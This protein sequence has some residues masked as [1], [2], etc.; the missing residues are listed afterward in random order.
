VVS[1]APDAELSG[2]RD[3]IFLDTPSDFHI[4]ALEGRQVFVNRDICGYKMFE[5]L[6]S[7]RENL[8]EIF[9]AVRREFHRLSGETLEDLAFNCNG[10][11]FDKREFIFALNVFEELGLIAFGDGKLTVYRGIKAELTDSALYR[12][13][14]DITKA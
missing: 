10:L 3:F 12:K 6:D 5:T 2:F 11:G 13:V 1:P 4:D 9:N 7:K 8:L 14:V